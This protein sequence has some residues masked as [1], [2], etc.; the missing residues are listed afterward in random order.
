[1]QLTMLL[2]FMMLYFSTGTADRFDSEKYD[3]Q[4]D[5]DVRCL[6]T[7][8]ARE[9]VTCPLD[10]MCRKAITCMGRCATDDHL[11]QSRCFFAWSDASFMAVVDC[12]HKYGC[13][14]NM[15]WGKYSCPDPAK[16]AAHRMDKFDV[17]TFA[18]AGPYFVAMGSDP[19]Y[20]CFDCQYLT[21]KPQE[22][23]VR[24]HWTTEL[25][26]AVRGATYV[27]WQEAPSVLVTNYNLLGMQVEEHYHI[28]DATPKGE[29]V[30][31][32]YCGFG[33]GGE[34]QGAVVYSQT[35]GPLPAQ[36]YQRFKAS[37]E[38]A[39]LQPWV[40]SFGEFCQPKYP[41]NMCRNVPAVPSADQ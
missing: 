27:L 24:T 14:P 7:H 9:M 20:D 16:L 38:K 3:V 12:G 13:L 39:D 18:K 15:T 35:P 37:I 4:A 33:S 36:V 32:F 1:M 6:A 34:Y 11:C 2:F 5:P 10:T 23:G 40:P 31:Y 25:E 19:V 28:L 26:G 30:L 29:Y 21:F 22:G 17:E 8:C 41:A